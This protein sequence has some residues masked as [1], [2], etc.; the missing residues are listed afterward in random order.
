[1]LQK[2][3]KLLSFS[4]KSTKNQIFTNVISFNKVGEVLEKWNERFKRENVAEP[5]E[6][7]LNI[8]AFNLGTKSVSRKH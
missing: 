5:L 4:Q 2:S 1:M 8:L 3:L 7:I 6:S